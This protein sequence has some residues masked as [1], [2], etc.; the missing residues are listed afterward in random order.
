[1]M[2]SLKFILLIIYVVSVIFL[3]IMDYIYD[4]LEKID[5]LMPIRNTILSLF[6]LYMIVGT[7]I[8]MPVIMVLSASLMFVY[9][10]IKNF[11]K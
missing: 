3:T 10:K 11:F 8:I 7:L 1:M 5:I 9:R 4:D 2:I 6:Y